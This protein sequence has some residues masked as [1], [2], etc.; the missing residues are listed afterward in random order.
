MPFGSSTVHEL[1]NHI[2]ARPH[3]PQLRAA[4]D[5]LVLILTAVTNELLELGI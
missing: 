1:E 2:K 4:T 5:N 3:L